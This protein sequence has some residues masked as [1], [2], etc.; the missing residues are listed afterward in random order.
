MKPTPVIDQAAADRARAF[1]AA[2]YAKDDKAKG[3]IGYT[4][5]LKP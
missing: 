3:K 5:F 2:E 4:G 1:L